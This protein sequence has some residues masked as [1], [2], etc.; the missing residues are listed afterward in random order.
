MDKNL[1]KP[2]VHQ[3]VHLVF[4]NA[5][6]IKNEHETALITLFIIDW[7]SQTQ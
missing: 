3:A 5:T 4:L 2:N 6:L 1:R 7:I